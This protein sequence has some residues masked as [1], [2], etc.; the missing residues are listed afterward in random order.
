MTTATASH[1]SSAPD[2]PAT[3][4]ALSTP[5][6]AASAERSSCS[7]ASSDRTGPV[8]RRHAA[9]SSVAW[10]A[11]VD[12]DHRNW[13][14]EGRR[15]GTIARGSLWWIGDWLAYGTL[16]WGESY[17]EAARVT[18]YDPKTLRNVRYV[19]SRFH[20]SLRRDDLTWSHHALLAAMGPGDQKHWLARAAADRLTVADLR[21]ELR[22]ANRDSD[23]S[24]DLRKLSPIDVSAGALEVTALL[25]PKCGH[26]F[27][28]A[29]EDDSS[30]GT[31]LPSSED[32]TRP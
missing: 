24:S 2:S 8:S 5:R 23:A 14:V 13:L 19:S 30:P 15:I 26:L 16:K 28:T 32:S 7:R 3:C 9:V 4:A 6:H 1:T 11:N 10:V 22:S 18:G 12:L 29:L 31:V 25:C 17:V 20:A 27:T 21:I